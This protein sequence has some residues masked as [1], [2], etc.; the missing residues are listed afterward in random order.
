MRNIMHD[1]PDE[2]CTV[3]LQHIH[4][5]TADD[6]LILIDDMVLPNQGA[7]WL[8]ATLDLMVM[9]SLGAMERSEQQWQTLLEAAGF[10]IRHIFTYTQDLRDSVIVAVPK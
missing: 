1:Y 5:A 10:R 2:K 7:H 9:S 4:S 6:S 3:I 8:A